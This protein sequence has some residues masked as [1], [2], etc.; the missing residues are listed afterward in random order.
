MESIATWCYAQ[1]LAFGWTHVTEFHYVHHDDKGQPYRNRAEM[2]ERL[3]RAANAV[4]IGLTILPVV[5]QTSGIGKP[6]LPTQKRFIS[7]DIDAWMEIHEATKSA[8]KSYKNVQTGTAFHSLR[9]VPGKSLLAIL[10]IIGRDQPVH[11]HAAEQPR[12][13]EECLATLGKRPVEWLLENTGGGSWL[14]VVHGTHMTPEETRA[15]ALSK[16]TVVICPT[17]EANLADGIFPLRSWRDHGGSIALGSDSNICLN[18]AEEIRLL[19]YGQRL[20]TGKR[21]AAWATTGLEEA[22]S[23]AE[24]L[25]RANVHGGM[26]AAGLSGKPLG[27]GSQF[28]ALILDS[29]SPSSVGRSPAQMLTAWTHGGASLL[30]TI[31]G[32]RVVAKDGRHVHETKFVEGWKKTVRKLLKTI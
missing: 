27:L 11:I 20:I 13:V 14:N 24:T 8:A 1:M 25:V 22:A 15:L 23:A 17:T 30:A 4:G 3:M 2:A 26:S 10:K 21:N 31:S 28:D 18:P 7:K 12:E 29:A 5:Y 16:S 32:G 6:A 19:D 9:A